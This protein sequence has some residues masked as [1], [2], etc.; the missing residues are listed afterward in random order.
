MKRTSFA[1]ITIL[2]VSIHTNAQSAYEE[3]VSIPD[4]DA[5]NPLTVTNVT[6][7]MTITANFKSNG[8]NSGISHGTGISIY[9]NPTDGKVNITSSNRDIQRVSVI[10]SCGKL[11]LQQPTITSH[12]TIDLSDQPAGIYFIKVHTRDEIILKKV[13]RAG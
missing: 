4:Y 3:P 5:T 1:L 7:D 10:D 8:T 12:L 6:S 2:F 11:V 9:P 13:N